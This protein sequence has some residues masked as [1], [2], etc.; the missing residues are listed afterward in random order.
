MM[1]IDVA[2]TGIV[3]FAAFEAWHVWTAVLLRRLRR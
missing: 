1:E 3:E 2:K